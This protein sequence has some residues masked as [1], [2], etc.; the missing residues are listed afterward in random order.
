MR[1]VK[2]AIGAH[3]EASGG[4]TITW[5]KKTYSNVSDR[6]SVTKTWKSENRHW[7]NLLTEQL[8]VVVQWDPASKTNK[9]TENTKSDPTWQKVQNL[10][11]VYMTISI[12]DYAYQIHLSKILVHRNLNYNKNTINCAKHYEITSVCWEFSQF[13]CFPFCLSF[14]GFFFFLL[15]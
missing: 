10:S 5:E 3:R 9:T 4:T 12:H 13:F 15:Q 2:P 14:V 11:C 8:M 6:M 7:T 1:G